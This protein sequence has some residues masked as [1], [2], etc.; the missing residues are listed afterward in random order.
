M[1][2]R[3]RFILVLLVV[4]VAT[5]FLYPTG[6]WYFGVDKDTKAIATGSREQIRNFS[7]DKAASDLE[8]LEAMEIGRAHV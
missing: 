7:Q 8:K 1:S 2:K 3:T 6:K 5:V 4:A